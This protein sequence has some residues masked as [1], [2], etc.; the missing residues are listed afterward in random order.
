MVDRHS[1]ALADQRLRVALVVGL[2]VALAA[3]ILACLLGVAGYKQ[4]LLSPPS[5][6]VRIGQVEYSAPCPARGLICSKSPPFYA[7]WRAEEQPDGSINYR[8]LFFIYRG[9]K[10]FR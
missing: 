1:P 10:W 7:I 8:E 6:V 4:R 5:F 3:T 9:P 2:S